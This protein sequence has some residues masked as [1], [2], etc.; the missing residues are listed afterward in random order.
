EDEVRRFRREARDVAD[1]DHPHIVPV[2]EVGE[3]AGQLFFSMKLL[4]GGSLAQQ[5]D[6]FLGHPRRA[7]RLGATVARAVQDAHQRQLL[8]RDLKPGNVLLDAEGQPHVADFGLAKRLGGEGEASQ[9]AAVGTPEYVAPEQARTEHRLT[10]AADVYGLG[11]ILYALLAGRP[12]FRAETSWQTLLQVVAEE[13]APPSAYRSG[14][15]RDLDLICL[16]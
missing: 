2:Y 9:S 16:K 3:H 8:H 10:T 13:P 7:A 4:E 1:L 12:P 15:P 5:L 11:G 14:V 6:T